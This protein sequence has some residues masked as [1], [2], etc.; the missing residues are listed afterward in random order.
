MNK[1]KLASSS[2]TVPSANHTAEKAK[3]KNFSWFGGIWNNII[4]QQAVVLEV[5]KTAIG[6]PATPK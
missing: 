4:G 2:S 1:V 5:A 6:M 3:Q